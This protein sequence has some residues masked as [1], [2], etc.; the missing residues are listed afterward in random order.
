[1]LDSADMTFGCA[2]GLDL[3]RTCEQGAGA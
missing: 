1:V 3:L 2:A